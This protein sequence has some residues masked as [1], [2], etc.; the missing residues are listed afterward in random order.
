MPYI[1]KRRLGNA[2][3]NTQSDVKR[4][5][6]KYNKYYQNRQWKLLRDYYYM[7]H[8]ICSECALNGKSTPAEEVHH[9]IP[10]S[11]FDTEED[12]F[13]AL[14][15]HENLTCLCKQC[16]LKIHHKLKKPDNFEQTSYYKKIHDS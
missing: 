2:N 12:K 8:P 10:W 1:T 11:W 14:L 4:H 7:L 5:N 9:K 16:H 6:D 13:K 3:R 15:D